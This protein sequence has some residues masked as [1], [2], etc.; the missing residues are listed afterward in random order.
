[1]WFAKRRS[2]LLVAF[3]ALSGAAHGAQSFKPTP[4]PAVPKPAFP[5]PILPMPAPTPTTPAAPM[6]SPILTPPNLPAPPPAPAA[7]P[8]STTVSPEC[9]GAPG[10]PPLH[11]PEGVLS[12]LAEEI[13]KELIK[14][15]AEGKSLDSCV[16][17]EPRPPQ[18][19]G[20]PGD[21]F[22]PLMEC[23]GSNDLS[24]A[25]TR[26]NQCLAVVK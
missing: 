8:P 26:W 10:C 7:Q 3:V 2:A 19:Y 21:Q 16:N 11:E 20:L 4:A 6:P 1:M 14:C 18:L 12:E 23:L 17:D 22:N 24:V 25:K 15:E 13:F 5:T 9:P